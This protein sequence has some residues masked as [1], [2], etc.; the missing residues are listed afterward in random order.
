MGINGKEMAD[1]LVRQGSTCPLAG[2]DPALGIP[3]KVATDMIRDW[4]NRKP[5]SWQP[6]HG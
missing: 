2:P 4:T 6:I 5:E 3:A 1:Q